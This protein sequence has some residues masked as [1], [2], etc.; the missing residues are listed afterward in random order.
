VF[1]AFTMVATPLLRVASLSDRSKPLRDLGRFPPGSFP[2]FHSQ[3]A[4][5]PIL[6]QGEIIVA[7]PAER[8]GSVVA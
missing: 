2:R 3:F 5:N 1:T 8:D 4:F 7:P 6:R